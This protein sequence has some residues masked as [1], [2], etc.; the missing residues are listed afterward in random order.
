[1]S[2]LLEFFDVSSTLVGSFIN[3]LHNSVFRESDG[4][5][6][7]LPKRH[8]D[9]GMGYERLVSVIQNKRSNYDTDIFTPLFDAIQKVLF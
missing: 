2:R 8:I 5:L 3:I 6:K 7:V 4:K 9:C 1:M